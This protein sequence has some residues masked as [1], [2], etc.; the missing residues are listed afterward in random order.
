MHA[1]G[2]S[3]R[4]RI[5]NTLNRIKGSNKNYTGICHSF[6]AEYQKAGNPISYLSWDLARLKRTMT[7]WPKFSGNV[8]FPV[9]SGDPWY[10]RMFGLGKSAGEAYGSKGSWNPE[11]R[12]GALRLELLDWLIKDFGETK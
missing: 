12:Y 5:R 7:R 8:W 11:T 10:K 4:T 9:P 3:Q 6:I 2:D 1:C